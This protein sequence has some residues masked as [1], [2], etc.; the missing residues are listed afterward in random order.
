MSSRMMHG[1]SAS[2]HKTV[3]AWGARVSSRRAR[4]LARPIGDAVGLKLF[5]MPEAA[6]SERHVVSTASA[7]FR[8]QFED[9]IQKQR[10]GAAS[11]VDLAVRDKTLALLQK[12]DIQAAV[13][14]SFW[15]TSRAC[16]ESP[17]ESPDMRAAKPVP[18]F[19]VG[20]QAVLEQAAAFHFVHP[21]TAS[22]IKLPVAADFYWKELN[23]A[24]FPR[25][26]PGQVEDDDDEDVAESAARKPHVHTG[27]L[28]LRS[29]AASVPHPEKEF[30]GGEDAHFVY[31]EAQAIGVADGVG[32]WANVGVDAGIYA[33]ELM[34]RTRDAIRDSAATVRDPLD[35][36]AR[37][38]AETHSQGSAT[39][40]VLVLN[41]DALS[42]VNVGD[43]AFVVIRDDRIVFKSPV[44]QHRFNFPFQLA[45]TRG[46]PITSAETFRLKAVP[47]D[48]V[49]MG[50]DGLFD[51]VFDFELLNIVNVAKRGKLLPHEIANHLASCARARGEDTQ[52]HSPF[53]KA[54]MDAGHLYTGGK[55]DDITVVVSFVCSKHELDVNNPS[56]TG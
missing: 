2:L 50:T 55:L 54:A 24:G 56:A 51:N 46:D 7:G 20:C 34:M 45:R 17:D 25:P 23:N 47:G 26:L 30:K 33:K 22:A 37:A 41:D 5:A 53:A 1:P 52:R 32:G 3:A 48:I 13:E 12:P 11:A 40:C 8:S 29:A 38:H 21:M 6:N 9:L 27:S 49:V 35:A 42:A 18:P 19:G 4:D 43:S 28:C 10:Q 44:Q 14:A 15:R 39:A 36:L 16:G 31:G